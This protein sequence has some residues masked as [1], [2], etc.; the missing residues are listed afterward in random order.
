MSF[1]CRIIA[2]TLVAIFVFAS[3]GLTQE[4]GDPEDHAASLD[5]PNAEHVG[6]AE[7]QEHG[8]KHLGLR[9]EIVVFVGA[10]DEP[11]HPTEFTSGLEYIY[12]IA[13]RW[14]IGAFFDYAGGSL[15]NSVLGVPVVYN[16][17]GHWLLTAAP[18]IEFH[19][20]RGDSVEGHK[21]ETQS[22]TDENEKHFLFRLGVGYNISL[23]E[24][25]SL[26]PAVYLDLVK[27]E[28][29]WVYGLNFAYKF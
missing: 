21:S 24:H 16:P 5:E 25:Y 11:G 3:P 26:A 18:G 9:N 23:G 12:E 1:N 6:E 20:G 27:G 17:G 8:A 13:H 22:E 2:T 28:K 7:H 15:R 4:P 14:G 10:T 19:N 29:V